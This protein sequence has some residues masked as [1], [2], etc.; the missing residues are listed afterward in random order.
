MRMMPFS[1]FAVNNMLAYWGS[2]L[3]AC[4]RMYAG[5]TV[6]FGSYGWNLLVEPLP[7][8]TRKHSLDGWPTSFL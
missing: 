1:I 8:F 7:F 6:F 4:S 5:V 3:G 2:A